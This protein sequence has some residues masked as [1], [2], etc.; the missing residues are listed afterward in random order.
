MGM[1]I[2]QG[3][4]MDGGVARCVFTPSSFWR[5]LGVNMKK[6]TAHLLSD[7]EKLSVSPC[8][9]TRCDA[10]GSDADKD[11]Y[12]VLQGGRYLCVCGTETGRG[13][14]MLQEPLDVGTKED[15]QCL[16]RSRKRK[17]QQTNEKGLEVTTTPVTTVAAATRCF[18]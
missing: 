2:R 10:C 13:H 15:F 16:R 8:I 18:G 9:M 7:T 12:C 5:V 11:V 14:R 3:G 4:K 17:R 1:R 6:Y